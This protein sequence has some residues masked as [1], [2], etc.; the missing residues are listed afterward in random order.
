LV[1]QDRKSTGNKL[2]LQIFN[3]VAFFPLYS[4]TL[5]TEMVPVEART[6]YNSTSTRV[7]ICGYDSAYFYITMVSNN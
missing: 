7:T 6:Y 3:G 2:I 4:L 1:F 5:D